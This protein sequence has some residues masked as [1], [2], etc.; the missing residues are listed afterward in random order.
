MSSANGPNV[1][2]STVALWNVF[3][4][5]RPLPGDSGK[6]LAVWPVEKCLVAFELF[7]SLDLQGPARRSLELFK[8][9]LTSRFA[10]PDTCKQGAPYLNPLRPASP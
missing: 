8:R 4:D 5:G 2:A 7:S 6:E 3:G 1:A 10:H 9:A